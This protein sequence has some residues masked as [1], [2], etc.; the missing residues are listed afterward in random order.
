MRARLER[1][2]ET[3]RI[4]LHGL[5]VVAGVLLI[6]GMVGT[7]G[8]TPAPTDLEQATYTGTAVRSGWPPTRTGLNSAAGQLELARLE[9]GRLE[10]IVG[11]SRQYQVAADLAELIY[12]TALQQGLDPELAF[13][14]VKM[15]SQFKPRARSHAGAIGLTQVQL[16]TARF[17]EPDITLERLYD[18]ATNLRIGLSFLRDLI[19]AYDDVSLALLAYNWGPSRLRELLAQG[20]DPRNGYASTIMSGYPGTW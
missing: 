15:E 1:K 13:R 4:S 19:R 7:L 5:G 6:G 14:L 10:A 3:Q 11:F 17:Y 12:E 20:R 2:P 18:P 9:L 16:P 8:P